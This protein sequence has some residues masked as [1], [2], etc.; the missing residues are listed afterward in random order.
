MKKTKLLIVSVLLFFVGMSVSGQKSETQFDM[1]LYGCM[2]DSLAAHHLDFNQEMDKFE[3]LLIQEKIFESSS[4]SPCYLFFEKMAKDGNMPHHIDASQFAALY[5]VLS[6]VNLYS[7][8]FAEVSKIKKGTV[9]DSKYVLFGVK[10]D[11][12]QNQENI[13]LNDAAKTIITVFKPSDFKKPCY[14][15]PILL[16]VLSMVYTD[17]SADSIIDN[18]YK[19]GK[20]DSITSASIRVNAKNELLLNDSLVSNELMFQVLKMYVLKHES[21]SLI[22]IYLGGNEDKEVYGKIINLIYSVYFEVKEVGAMK[23]FGKEYLLLN[24]SEMN[25]IKEMYPLNVEFPEFTK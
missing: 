12:L 14:R 10:V 16:S 17:D 11:G 7:R 23:K 21:K 20:Y 8:C 9:K 1:M 3:V 15:N 4:K 18:E 24:D 2:V 22:F 25:A 19:R 5:E 13:Y 6:K